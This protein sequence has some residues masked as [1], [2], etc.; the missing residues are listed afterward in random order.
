MSY[1]ECNVHVLPDGSDSPSRMALA[2]RRLGYSGIIICNHSD[3]QE[4][5]GADV[6]SAVKGIEVAWG[7]EL[8]SDNPRRLHTQAASFRNRVDFLAVHGGQ[9]KINRAACEDSNVDLLVH[10]QA[11]RSSLGVA[12]AKAARDNQVSIGLDLSLMMLHRGGFRVR[13]LETVQRDLAMVDKFDLNLMI[14]TSAFSHLDLRAPR[15]LM[16]MARLLGLEQE[17]IEEAL[18]LPKTILELNRKRWVGPGVE[19]L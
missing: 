19:I 13:W 16:A 12:A 17:R 15:D 1:Y 9:E 2:A 3:S 4:I 7:V 8:V 11:E 14:T 6:V 5:F 18:S 10:S